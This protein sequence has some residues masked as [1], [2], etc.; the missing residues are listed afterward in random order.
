MTATT[1]TSA[2]RDFGLFTAALPDTLTV[3]RWD[4]DARGDDLHFSAYGVTLRRCVDVAHWGEHGPDIYY[5]L[6]WH[7]GGLTVEDTLEAA[8]RAIVTSAPAR[9][10]RLTAK[11]LRG[12]LIPRCPA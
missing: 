3:Q 4:Q 11:T 9:S 5:S 10:Q 6:D 7:K 1:T 12:R 8:V 2:P